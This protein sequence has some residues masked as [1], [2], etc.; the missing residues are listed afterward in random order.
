MEKN[1]LIELEKQFEETSAFKQ[2]IT[3]ELV[4]A[5]HRTGACAKRLSKLNSMQA[6]LE[7]SKEPDEVVARKLDHLKTELDE[8]EQ[9]YRQLQSQEHRLQKAEVD[10]LNQLQDAENAL[11]IEQIKSR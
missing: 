8:T 1:D 4:G 5:Q 9:N 11:K 10:A 3:R 6:L 7:G 2:S